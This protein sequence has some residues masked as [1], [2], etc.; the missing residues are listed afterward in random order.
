MD[1]A[2]ISIL[3]AASLAAGAV[4]SIAGGGTLLTFP[5]LTLVLGP[6]STALVVA[7]ATSTVALF[8]GSLAAIWGYRRELSGMRPWIAPLMIPSLLGDA[9]GTGLVAQRDPKEFALMVPWLILT[10]TTLFML[11]PTISR[12][13]GIGKPQTAASPGAKLGIILFQFLIAVYGGYFGAGIGILMLS[14]LAIMG[15][16]DI[17]RMNGVKTALASAING[18]SVA[19]FVWF[20]KVNWN[21]A[22]PMVI[23]SIIGGYVGASVARRLDKN[24]VR[25]LVVAIG[26]VLSTYY[27]GRIHHI[28]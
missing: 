5:A 18:V 9:I 22:I 28:W 11:Q 15:M 4:N 2:Q 24:V 8:P 1:I 17:H 10:A 13:T 20:D 14:S 25:Y 21:L 12:W 16:S 3:C 6:S 27:F 7:N 19:M 26:L 23:S